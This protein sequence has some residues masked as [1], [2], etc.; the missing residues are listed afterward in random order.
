MHSY[1]IS[2]TRLQLMPIVVADLPQITDYANNKNISDALISIPH[3]FTKKDATTWY[4][5]HE[6]GAKKGVQITFV[7]KDYNNSLIGIIGLSINA[8]HNHAEAGYWIAEHHWAHGYATEALDA[9][10]KFG[11]E[12]MQ[13]H[14]IFATHFKRNANSGKVMS[15]CGMVQEG[16]LKDHYKKNDEYLCIV[17]YSIINQNA[18]S[19]H[20]VE[21]LN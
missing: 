16:E 15:K 12:K 2:T 7:I 21:R 4:K 9:V 6:H 20:K 8:T 19:V 3:P 13:L 17:Q 5:A 1:Q 14:K 10:I 18:D 11:F